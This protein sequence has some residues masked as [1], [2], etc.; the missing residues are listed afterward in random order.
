[1]ILRYFCC[2]WCCARFAKLITH[3]E[4]INS[5]ASPRGEEQCCAW[6]NCSISLL[7]GCCASSYPADLPLLFLLLPLVDGWLVTWCCVLQHHELLHLFDYYELLINLAG[8]DKLQLAQNPLTGSCSSGWMMR[9]VTKDS[10][11]TPLSYRSW[12]VQWK[13][14][15]LEMNY[16]SVF[17]AGPEFFCLCWLVVVVDSLV[18]G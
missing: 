17:S 14:K 15:Y 2:C 16:C 10:L 13:W 18:V 6:R 1:M 7:L 3:I 8:E 12:K 5:F 4:L 11:R 9:P